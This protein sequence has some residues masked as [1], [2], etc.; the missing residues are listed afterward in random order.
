MLR[1]VV[2][3]VSIKRSGVLI[4]LPKFPPISLEMELGAGKALCVFW[5][6]LQPLAPSVPCIF[7]C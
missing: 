1:V 2:G 5:S 6:S 7:L 3:M 4:P